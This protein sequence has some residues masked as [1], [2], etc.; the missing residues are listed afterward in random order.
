MNNRPAVRHQEKHHVSLFSP[1]L[2]NDDADA[3]SGLIYDLET[4]GHT[5]GAIV[6]SP[7]PYFINV[8]SLQKV[9][10]SPLRIEIF[11]IILFLHFAGFPVRMRYV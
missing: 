11:F 8:G 10:K 9:A 6:D 5:D 7:R 3:R 4:A 1:Y 2:Y